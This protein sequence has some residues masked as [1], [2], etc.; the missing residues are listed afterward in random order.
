MDSASKANK[1]QTATPVP[2][3]TV[4]RRRKEA[5]TNDD[6]IQEPTLINKLLELSDDDDDLSEDESQFNESAIN[7]GREPLAPITNIN[8]KI[9][10]GIPD[11]KTESYVNINKIRSDGSNE[12]SES[13][14][15]LSLNTTPCS[16]RPNNTYSSSRTRN[17]DNDDIRSTLRKSY[18]PESAP[19][20]PFRDMV[21]VH[22]ICSWLCVNSDILLL[23]YN[24][25]LSM[26][27]P[28][29][30]TFN[31]ISPNFN[32]STLAS[33]VPQMPKQ[34]DRVKANRD[35]LKELKCLFLRVRNP[36]KSVFEDLVQQIF[37]CDLNS[38]E[39]IDW[40]RAANRNFSDFRNK[41]LDSVEE[42]IEIFKEKRALENKDTTVRF[43]DEYEIILFVNENLT[44]D[45]LQRWLL[46]ATNMTKL[47]DQNSLRVLQRFVRGSLLIVNYDS[48]DTDAMKSLDK[49]TKKIAVPSR[50]GKNIAS[51]LEL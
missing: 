47:R 24:M 20:V 45:I 11:E 23:A 34:E 32:S 5:I 12:T 14:F 15:R 18:N 38:S 10:N 30:N 9:H 28:A 39:G 3:T 40:L 35:F 42:A 4:K 21:N 13:Y 41:F 1:H 17:I 26:Q 29:A 48:R 31:I 33:G 2:K 43:L 50:N 49:I 16:N 44:L 8:D 6:T 22:Q 51:N 25:Y 37:N 19:P 46:S 36:K 7:I 27:T